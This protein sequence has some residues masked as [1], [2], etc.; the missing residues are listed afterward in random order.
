MRGPQTWP[1]VELLV[2]ERIRDGLGSVHV[3]TDVPA[4]AAATSVRVQRVG[5]PRSQVLDQA[6]ILLEVRAPDRGDASDLTG[7]VRDLLR[8]L[9]GAHDEGTVTGVQ[10]VGGPAWLPDPLTAAPRFTLTA[11][12]MVKPVDVPDST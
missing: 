5:G 9:P 6:R 4:A 7:Q 8:R 2:I 3:G 10:E 1:D 11:L 12:V